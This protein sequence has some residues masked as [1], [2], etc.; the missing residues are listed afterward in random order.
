MYW[1][2]DSKENARTAGTVQALMPMHTL[3]HRGSAQ[4]LCAENNSWQNCQESL[5]SSRGSD[6]AIRTLDVAG[7]LYSLKLFLLFFQTF[8]DQ[9]GTLRD[10]VDCAHALPHE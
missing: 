6:S 8:V 1:K 10:L 5:A 4:G 9:S 3:L 7:G 2:H